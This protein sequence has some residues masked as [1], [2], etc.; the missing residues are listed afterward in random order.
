MDKPRLHLRLWLDAESHTEG[1]EGGRK[2]KLKQTVQRVGRVTL[3][4]YNVFVTGE[5]LK[6]P[7]RLAVP[8]SHGGRLLAWH[9]QTPA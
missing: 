6:F 1:K 7:P 9:P 3:N 8:Y 4:C 5:K 2:K